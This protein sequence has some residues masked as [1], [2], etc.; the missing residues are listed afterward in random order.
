MDI[1]LA[2]NDEG[3]T[4]KS[5]FS[6]GDQLKDSDWENIYPYW[7]VAVVDGQIVAAIQMC[8]SRPVGRLEHLLVNKEVGK[9]TATKAADK[10]IKFG[11]QAMKNNGCPLI[12][13]YVTFKN[14]PIKNLIKKHY[15]A[16]LVD[17][18]S[19]WIWRIK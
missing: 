10:L 7:A 14:K 1:R 6:N 17:S 15:S 8:L 5:M 16:S 9:F 4:I 11:E 18:G 12:S 3:L 13:G 19:M 2:R